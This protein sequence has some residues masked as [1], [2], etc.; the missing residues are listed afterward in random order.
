MMPQSQQQLG[1]MATS[2]TDERDDRA[3]MINAIEDASAPELSA[4]RA[5]DRIRRK[6][7]TQM[8]PWSVGM[9]PVPVQVVIEDISETAIGVIHSE[10]V[11]PGRKFLITVPRAYMDPIV[12]EGA[13]TRCEQRGQRLYKIWLA[14]TTPIEHV[15]QAK[16]SMTLTTPRTKFLFLI[17]GAISLAIAAFW[18]I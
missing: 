15:E 4:R 8:V 5:A 3:D 9:S 18:P 2:I 6:V 12:I 13:A 1:A 11:E 16:Q 14:S 10:P 7:A 17:F